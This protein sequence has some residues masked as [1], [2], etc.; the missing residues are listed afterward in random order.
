MDAAHFVDDSTAFFFGEFGPA[1]VSEDGGELGCRAVS[2]ESFLALGLEVEVAILLG[3]LEEGADFGEFEVPLSFERVDELGALFGGEL[4]DPAIG[5]GDFEV[6]HFLEEAKAL[7]DEAGKGGAAGALFVVA[8]TD[9]MALGFEGALEE[10]GFSCGVSKTVG[11]DVGVVSDLGGP[12]FFEFVDEHLAAEV[13]VANALILR[14]ELRQVLAKAAR[15]GFLHFLRE[16][17]D[18]GFD[19]AFFFF[20]VCL[21]SAGRLGLDFSIGE[22]A[23]TLG[24]MVEGAAEFV[25]G[26]PFVQCA[27]SQGVRE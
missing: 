19:L 2:D 24:E 11:E 12:D 23:A 13:A 16:L 18:G 17:A 8:G 22:E 14:I 5:Q 1:L 10:Y 15:A 21:G 27:R 25:G 6:V 3:E 20:F 7:G 26:E 9:E 4:A